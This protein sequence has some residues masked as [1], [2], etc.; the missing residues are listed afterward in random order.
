MVGEGTVCGWGGSLWL[1]GEAVC[2]WGGGQGMV[3][4]TSRR[5]VGVGG[6]EGVWCRGGGRA[7]PLN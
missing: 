7:L 5:G 4:M 1:G 2:G 6:E 3:A